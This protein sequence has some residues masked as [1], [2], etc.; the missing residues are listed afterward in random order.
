MELDNIVLMDCEERMEKSVNSFTDALSRVK[1]GRASASLVRDVM[2]D[3]WGCP[4]PLYQIANISTPDASQIVI[5]PYDKN[6][7]KDIVSVIYICTG[8]I[9]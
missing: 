4:T 7:L 5:K 8:D 9:M 3:Y 1:T 6:N 2:V